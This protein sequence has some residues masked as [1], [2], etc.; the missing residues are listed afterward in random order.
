LGSQK[1]IEVVG[2]VALVLSIMFLGY[3]LKRGNDIAEAE[4]AA[5]V[6]GDVNELITILLT[7]DDAA[8]VWGLGLRN[9]RS[10]DDKDKVKFRR[11]FN[12][13]LNIQEINM[14]FIQNGLVD[15]DFIEYYTQD[16]C[17]LIGANDGV[18]AH[19]Q[20]IKSGR[21]PALR[22]FVDTNCDFNQ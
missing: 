15:A 18:I 12:Y 7:D 22:D 20:Q 9:Y 19:W 13:A 6:L 3:E 2:L 1:V 5:T 14:K 21:A 10:L 16:T 11:L 8:R 17:A 4:A